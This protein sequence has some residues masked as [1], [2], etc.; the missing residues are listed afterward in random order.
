M[1]E[2]KVWDFRLFFCESDICYIFYSGVEL[3]SLLFFVFLKRWSTLFL[4][5]REKVEFLF[6][7]SY[8]VFFTFT[9][10]CIVTNFFVIKSTRCTNFT[11]LFCHETLHVSDL[12]SVH[13]REFIHCTL[14]NCIQVYCM[15]YRFVDSFRA[16]PGWNCGSILV[17]L[18]SSMTYTIAE[19]TV[20]K[21]LMM[22][23]RTVRNM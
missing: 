2:G 16:G 7:L 12:S 10:P 13:Y 14:S 20:N 5:K 9:W 4:F 1:L 3:Q 17:L 21:F 6:R 8:F 15:S 23:R 11:Y 19:C 22:Y 18:E